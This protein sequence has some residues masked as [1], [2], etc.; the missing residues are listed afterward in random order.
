MSHAQ[1]LRRLGENRD[2]SAKDRQS[3]RACCESFVATA[4]ER[5]IVLEPGQDP[6]SAVS[7][8]L[9]QSLKAHA[10]KRP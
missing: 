8:A 2:R 3:H 7:E 10:E 5:G 6:V 9:Q 4:L 1:R